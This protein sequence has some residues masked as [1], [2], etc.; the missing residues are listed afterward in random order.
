MHQALLTAERLRE[1]IAA[2]SIAC[3]E[4][5]LRMTASFGVADIRSDDANYDAMLQRADQAM[6]TA[7]EGGRNRVCLA[8]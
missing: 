6:Y 1:Q 5:E 7:K 3:R 8:L 2:Q 4:G